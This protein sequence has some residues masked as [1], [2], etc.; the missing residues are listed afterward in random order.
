MDIQ[1][2]GKAHGLAKTRRIATYIGKY[3]TKEVLPIYNKKRY[4]ITKGVKVPECQRKWLKA[5]NLNEAVIEIMRD[6]GLLVDD[7]FPALK[8]W[9]PG[10]LAFF[11]VGLD[12]L[13]EPPF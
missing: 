13:P 11:W 12:A 10:N 6:W 2:R 7:E 9:M 3:I 5:D 8:V 4:W 1:Y